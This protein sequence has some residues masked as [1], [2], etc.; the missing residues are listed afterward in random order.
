MEI[1]KKLDNICPSSTWQQWSLCWAD[2]T[3]ASLLLPASV[4][5]VIFWLANIFKKRSVQEQDETEP[6]LGQAASQTVNYYH[7]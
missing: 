2:L 4:L 3:A 6:L 5:I 1:I 7:F